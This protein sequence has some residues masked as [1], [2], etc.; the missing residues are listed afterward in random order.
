M[1]P[2]SPSRAGLVSQCMFEEMEATCGHHVRLLSIYVYEYMVS[3]YRYMVSMYTN[4]SVWS[5]LLAAPRCKCVNRV[6][7]LSIVITCT[8][9]IVTTLGPV[10]DVGISGVELPVRAVIT[11][12][13]F[14]TRQVSILH[15]HTYGPCSV[16][17]TNGTRSRLRA[18][19]QFSAANAVLPFCPVANAVLP[20][21][22]TFLYCEMGGIPICSENAIRTVCSHW[23][24]IHYTSA[25]WFIPSV[26]RRTLLR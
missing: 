3:M 20:F 15:L 7:C 10:R 1:G 24:S 6:C 2:A 13:A 26:V 14:H 4:A 21:Y 8:L 25:M 23:A 5:H 17:E 9:Y 19:S 22:R 18:L 11:H 12:P 16:P